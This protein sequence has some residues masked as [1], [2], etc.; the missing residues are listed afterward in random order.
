MSDDLPVERRL[1]ELC[2]ARG[3]RVIEYSADDIVQMAEGRVKPPYQGVCPMY[4]TIGR[5]RVAGFEGPQSVSK[6]AHLFLQVPRPERAKVFIPQVTSVTPQYRLWYSVID[7]D[8]QGECVELVDCL[9]STWSYEVRAVFREGLLETGYMA[10]RQ[11]DLASE[12][13]LSDVIGK[14]PNE[15]LPRFMR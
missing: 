15:V 3:M 5:L 11:E 12:F 14:G 9:P 13:D 1:D 8:V 4:D 10:A 2:S 7:S 6:F